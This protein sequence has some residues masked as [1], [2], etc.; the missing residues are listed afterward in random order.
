M[1]SLST[2]FLVDFRGKFELWITV[3]LSKAEC[4]PLFVCGTEKVWTDETWW[5]CASVKGFTLLDH[6]NKKTEWA[7]LMIGAVGWWKT[8]QKQ[9][10]QV[11]PRI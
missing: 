6:G 1:K 4:F 5:K 3:E 2:L 11:I 10:N 8:H 7:N 9:G